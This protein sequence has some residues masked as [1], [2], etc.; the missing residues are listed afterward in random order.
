MDGQPRFS[1]NNPA[2]IQPD[3]IFVSI[4]E[5]V[6]QKLGKRQFT[7]A[8]TGLFSV[9]LA[10]NEFQESRPAF[11][12]HTLTKQDEDVCIQIN[13]PEKLHQSSHSS[14]RDRTL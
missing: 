4:A 10:G 9:P 2:V 6:N 8:Q 12:L 7:G 13:R 1:L 5:G 3:K 11:I 14:R